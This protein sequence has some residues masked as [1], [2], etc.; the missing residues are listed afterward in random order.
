M[1]T[2]QQKSNE[3]QSLEATEFEKYR[4]KTRKE[5]FLDVMEQIIPWEEM[6][7][8]IA[9]Y[10]PN[11]LKAGRKPIGLECMLRIRFLQHWFELSD[12]AAEEAL[13]DSRALGQSISGG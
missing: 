11:P 6:C 3:Q 9:P 1:I 10:Y 7:E 13:Y 12:T 2:T 5:Q 4:K 8:V